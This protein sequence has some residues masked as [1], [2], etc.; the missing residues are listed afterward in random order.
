MNNHMYAEK[1][2]NYTIGKMLIYFRNNNINHLMVVAGGERSND[3]LHF[4]MYLY[5]ECVKNK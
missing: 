2:R 3:Y 4:V 1:L 5:Y